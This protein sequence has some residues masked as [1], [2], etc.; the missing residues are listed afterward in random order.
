MKRRV[1]VTGLG[2]ITPLGN[3]VSEFWQG[4]KD[5]KN[6][7][8]FITK[9]DTT[10]FKAKVAAE[11]KGYNPEE[12][13]IS[14]K[15]SKRFDL[16]SQYGIVAAKE[17]IKDANLENHTLDPYRF[18]VM[19]SSGIG[20]LNTL[21]EDIS[22]Y[23]LKGP[24]R[25]SPYFIPK[26]ISNMA[27]GNI[28]II[29]NAKGPN[30]SITTACASATHSI[31]EAMRKIQYGEADVMLA[32]GCEAS[33]NPVG[34]QGFAK[35]TAVTFSED[36]N[37]ASRPFDKNRNGFVMGEGAGVLVLE[38]YD[39]AVKRG[40]TIYAEVVGYAAT[41]DAYHMTAPEGEGATK[42]MEFALNDANIN[43]S[44]IDYINAHGTSTPLN[45][46]T[47]TGAIKAAFGDAANDLLVSSTKSMTGHL[48]GA[49]G[50]IEA[51]ACVKAMNDSIVP[52]TMNLRESDEE[53]DL[54]YVP[55][56]SVEK[57]LNYTLS[58]SLG[59]GGHNATIIFKRV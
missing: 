55:N 57:E 39:H 20:G 24:K 4:L 10:E 28:A 16:Y 27:A 37:N 32:G 49:A 50:G 33:I 36:P 25:I 23:A 21:Q 48:L 58:N 54:N 40:A 18:G 41:C 43:P 17:A 3:N 56:K 47:E 31:G 8:D 11:V 59:F 44:D 2:A 12:F 53:C 26:A 52:P 1:V 14:K 51:V 22:N 19:V 5:G 35:L 45:D 29:A 46:K 38:D 9:F 13:G 7:I 42:A 30:M 15:D 6:G 34:I